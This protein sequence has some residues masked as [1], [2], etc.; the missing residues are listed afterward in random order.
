MIE[1]VFTPGTKGIPVASDP[2]K[3]QELIPSNEDWAMV[4]EILSVNEGIVEAKKIWDTTGTIF[5]ASMRYLGMPGL[6]HDSLLTVGSYAV[7]HRTGDFSNS[8]PQGFELHTEDVT[9]TSWI[10]FVTADPIVYVYD[11]GDGTGQECE[12]DGHNFDLVATAPI[13]DLRAL[14][15][16]TFFHG[17]TPNWKRDR[18]YR[19]Q[20]YS[21][22]YLVDNPGFGTIAKTFYGTSTTTTIKIDVD[23]SGNIIEVSI[24]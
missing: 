11:N 3:S 8:G 1:N 10:C 12:F 22:F 20:R 5:R 14:D 17:D 24:A 15:P 4:V 16:A 19:G 9:K 13:L 18:V 6:P 2:K 7:F 23:G 21:T